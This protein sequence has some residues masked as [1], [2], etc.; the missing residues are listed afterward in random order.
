MQDTRIN[1]RVRGEYGGSVDCSVTAKPDRSVWYEVVVKVPSHPGWRIDLSKAVNLENLVN[2]LIQYVASGPGSDLVHYPVTVSTASSTEKEE[3]L[4]RA[5]S[6]S[7][8]DQ[9]LRSAFEALVW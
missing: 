9:A 3:S 1:V 4:V 2:A 6:R 5:T 8:L 7:E